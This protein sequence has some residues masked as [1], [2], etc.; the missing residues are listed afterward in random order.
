MGRVM[1]HTHR[2]APDLCVG[3]ILWGLELLQVSVQ[4]LDDQAVERRTGITL[5]TARGLGR[6]GS[7]Q[8]AR[9]ADVDRYDSHS[10]TPA[11][12]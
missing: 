4:G 11:P 5:F 6:Q 8:V 10:I 2:K 12:S 3:R 1:Q 7:M 9:H